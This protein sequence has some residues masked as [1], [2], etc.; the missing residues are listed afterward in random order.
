MAA[1]FCVMILA[2]AHLLPSTLTAVN[3]NSTDG[4]SAVRYKGGLDNGGEGREGFNA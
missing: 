4:R 2:K 1:L 3:G